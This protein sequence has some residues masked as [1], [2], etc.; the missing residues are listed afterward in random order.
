MMQKVRMPWSVE[1]QSSER[2]VMNLTYDSIYE[3][4]Q[5]GVWLHKKELIN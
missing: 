1:V 3:K 5:Y 2:M 4:D